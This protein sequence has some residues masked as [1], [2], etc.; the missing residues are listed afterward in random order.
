MKDESLNNNYHTTSVTIPL[1]VHCSVLFSLN[2]FIVDF[3][4]SSTIRVLHTRYI[5]CCN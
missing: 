5:A 2:I 4:N 3:Q 1:E